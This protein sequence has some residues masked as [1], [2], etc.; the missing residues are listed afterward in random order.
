MDFYS[1]GHEMELSEPS[2]EFARRRI[3]C[4]IGAL[5]K[6]QLNQPTS[7]SIHYEGCSLDDAVSAA[8]LR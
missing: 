5:L 6:E 2:F 1:F 7:E 8:E 4:S 3:R